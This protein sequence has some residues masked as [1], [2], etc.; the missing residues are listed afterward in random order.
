M[1]TILL[2]PHEQREGTRFKVWQR[3]VGSPVE[4]AANTPDTLP[5]QRI[6]FQE[7]FLEGERDLVRRRGRADERGAR[8]RTQ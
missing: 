1:F 7:I 2:A 3:L 6:S 4:F 8:V 5:E